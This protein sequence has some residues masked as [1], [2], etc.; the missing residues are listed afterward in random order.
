MKNLMGRGYQKFMREGLR[1]SFFILSGLS[2][3]AGLKPEKIEWG[4]RCVQI[5]IY[6]KNT[7][8]VNIEFHY[9]ITIPQE[10]IGDHRVETTMTSY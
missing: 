7:Q 1:N 3:V 9:T 4:F 6:K 10:G 2:V 5:A 8:K